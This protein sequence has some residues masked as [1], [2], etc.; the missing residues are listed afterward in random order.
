MN[1]GFIFSKRLLYA[2]IFGIVIIGGALLLAKSTDESPTKITTNT[3]EIPTKTIILQADTSINNENLPTNV[4]VGETLTSPPI[5]TETDIL[6]R[7]VLKPYLEQSST[8]TYSSQNGERIVSNATKELFTLAFTPL[9]AK[10]ILTSQ[11]SS[12]QSIIQ[13]KKSLYT[14]LK[15]IFELDEYELTIYARA[16]R[17]NDAVEFDSLASIATTYTKAADATLAITAPHEVSAIHLEIINALYQFATVLTELAKGYDDPAASLS[18]TGNFVAA[19]EAVQH[20]FSRLQTYFIL[21]E[22]DKITI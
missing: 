10:D 18:G 6:T 12:K 7:N 8:N 19:E 9:E 5:L 20:A 3:T 22:V 1:N 15:P 21:A 16:V 2:S 13:Y 14:A 17:D 4:E 11:D